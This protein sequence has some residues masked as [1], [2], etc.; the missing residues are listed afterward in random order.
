[1]ELRSAWER[2]RVG[3][4]GEGGGSS[5]NRNRDKERGRERNRKRERGLKCLHSIFPYGEAQQAV[6]AILIGLSKPW[7]L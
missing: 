2:N 1:M 3:R 4:E 5:R 7:E 6:D